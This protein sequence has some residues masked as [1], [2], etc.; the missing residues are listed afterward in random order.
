MMSS[1]SENYG[2]TAKDLALALDSLQLIDLSRLSLNG[3]HLQEA[4]MEQTKDR[5]FMGAVNLLLHCIQHGSQSRVGL[6]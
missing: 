5:G 6:Q 3:A 1:W 4:A 2:Q